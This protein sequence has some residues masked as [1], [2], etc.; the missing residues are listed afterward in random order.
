MYTAGREQ[1]ALRGLSVWS[2]RRF[3]D[4]R[5]GAARRLGVFRRTGWTQHAQ[6]MVGTNDARVGRVL[7]SIQKLLTVHTSASRYSV[8]CF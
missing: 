2:R 6:A 5:A 1:A 7:T 4:F 3:L 8:Y